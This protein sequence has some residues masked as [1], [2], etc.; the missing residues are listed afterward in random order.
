[1]SQASHSTGF[2]CQQQVKLKS[3][4]GALL[5]SMTRL[6]ELGLLWWWSPLV[7]AAEITSSSQFV[8]DNTPPAY[9]TCGTAFPQLMDS[10]ICFDFPTLTSHPTSL[11]PSL[12]SPSLLLPQP[13]FHPCFPS[14]VSLGVMHKGQC[15]PEGKG[16][17]RWTT[18]QEEVKAGI[19]LF[20]GP[21]HQMHK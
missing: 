13:L 12:L 8:G 16:G 10:I 9:G 7:S 18:M 19:L 15:R 6:M 17:R 5:T 3:S 21:H 4:V 14:V 2:E 1:M 11:P 20:L